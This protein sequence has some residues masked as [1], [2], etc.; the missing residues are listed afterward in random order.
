MIFLSL[1]GLIAAL[2]ALAYFRAPGWV[3]A[4]AGAAWLAALSVHGA[5]APAWSAA[6][7]TVL[8]VASALLLITPLRRG[9]PGGALLAPFRRGLSPGS[10]N[11]PAGRGPGPA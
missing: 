11:P 3:W 9:L 10:H 2:F 6:L 1:I 8:I 4:A 5:L 7:L